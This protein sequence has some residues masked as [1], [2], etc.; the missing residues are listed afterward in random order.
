MSNLTRILRCGWLLVVILPV[1][2]CQ[3][4]K[5]DSSRAMPAPLRDD[6]PYVINGKAVS[7]FR[8]KSFQLY[9]QGKLHFV[10]LYGIETPT[11]DHDFYWQSKRAFQGLIR[12][13]LVRVKIVQRDSSHHEIGFVFCSSEPDSADGLQP[14][15]LQLDVGL[16]LIRLGLAL[17]D[18]TDFENAN[19]Y[20]SEEAEA[21]RDRRGFWGQENL[22]WRGNPRIDNEQ[23][24]NGAHD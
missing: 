5:F 18:G 17:Y 16:E 24:S 8:G 3:D 6:F 2:G 7:K 22:D 20:R 14:D 19:Q 9:S 15:D 1:V 11:R 23:T 13:K 10:V 12:R 4:W 21:R